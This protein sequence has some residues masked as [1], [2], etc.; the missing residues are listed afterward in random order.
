MTFRASPAAHLKSR[1]STP[2]LRLPPRL[3]AQ[4]FHTSNGEDW[5]RLTHVLN[6]RLQRTHK[7]FDMFGLYRAVT[8]RGGFINR[9]HAR[10]N[11]SMVE[12][13][14]EMANHY[15]GHTYTDIGTLLLNTY[16]KT[17][18][19][20]EEEHPQDRNVAKCAV[21]GDAPPAPRETESVASP[22]RRRRARTRPNRAR[23]PGA[24][25]RRAPS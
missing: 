11:L 19:E 25:A 7:P 15:D 17:F 21:C 6:R 2:R 16:Q 8:S 22:N 9:P 13:F 20:Y 4:A 3:H 18:L 23:T 12:I 5:D 10:K 24:C 1:V 14:R